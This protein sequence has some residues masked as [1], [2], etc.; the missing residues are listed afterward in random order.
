MSTSDKNEPD[1]AAIAAKAAAV[2]GVL[3]TL[4]AL[5][6]YGGKTAFSVFVG[7][8]IAVANLVTMRGI[9]RALLPAPEEPAPK[10]PVKSG[11]DDLDEMAER[12]IA[13]DEATGKDEDE[14][15]KKT[16]Q[17]HALHFAKSASLTVVRLTRSEAVQET[18]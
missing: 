9:I 12:E 6:L 17:D 8:V 15:D 13:K 2:F 5:G 10:E 1:G 7:A 14:E 3:L 4:A 16:N 18:R 11:I